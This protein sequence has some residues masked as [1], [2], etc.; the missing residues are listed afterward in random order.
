MED[1]Q[2][3]GEEDTVKGTHMAMGLR[4]A[5]EDALNEKDVIVV[6]VVAVVVEWIL[7]DTEEG[8]R[9][10]EEEEGLMEEGVLEKTWVVER[11]QREGVEEEAAE[12]RSHLPS[13]GLEP[14]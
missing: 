11:L 12:H 6:A 5:E 8:R 1:R 7:P 9:M 13:H 10:G 2:E 3:M 4:E 14:H